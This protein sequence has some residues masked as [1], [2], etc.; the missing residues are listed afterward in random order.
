MVGK[1]TT[2]QAPLITIV[3]P[4]AVGKTSVSLDLAAKLGGEIVSADSRLFYL[5]MD[6]GTA[7]PSQSEQLRV[8]HHL[9]DIVKPDQTLTLAEYQD[10]AYA[11]I[12]QII[13]RGKI[14]FLV[15]GSGQHVRAVIEG[16]GIP[17]VAPDWELRTELEA[18]ADTHGRRAL[19]TRLADLDP[20]A[21]HR[22][23]YR[24]QRRVVRAI[25]GYNACRPA[26]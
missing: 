3:G 4:T 16:W 7:K 23:D 2:G 19:H 20:T 22:I 25:G 11:A 21:A 8:C 1:N 10:R 24:N 26:D 9:V 12:D 5:G 13:D 17:Q 14:P 15:G 18:F 6:I